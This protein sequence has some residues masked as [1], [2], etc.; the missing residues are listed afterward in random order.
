MKSTRD[1][2]THL[3]HLR[4]VAWAI[5][6][7]SLTAGFIVTSCRPKESPGESSERP[8]SS[9][10]EVM[11]T[12]EPLPPDLSGCTRIDLR[13]VPPVTSWLGLNDDNRHL[14]SVT[15]LKYLEAAKVV[16]LE[17]RDRIEALAFDVSQGKYDERTHGIPH[18]ADT[19]E[20]TGY[21]DGKPLPPFLARYNDYIQTQL[22]RGDVFRYPHGLPSIFARPLPG[23]GPLKMRMDCSENLL[24]LYDVISLYVQKEKVYPPAT[25]WCDAITSIRP[26]AGATEQD[27]RTRFICPDAG[28]GICHYGMNPDCTPDSA[29][30]TVLLFETRA[31]WNQHGGSESFV[32]NNHEPIGGCVLLN[33][34]GLGIREEPA[35]LPKKPTVLFIRTPEEAKGLRW[36]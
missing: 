16:T 32:L 15:E 13:F 30:E 12:G 10:G 6:G 8:T 18:P 28:K 23:V 9:S 31:G 2:G 11:G 21:R 25:E 1:H 5:T 36:K 29:P 26:W 14:L 24:L 19:V 27:I 7:V 20:V 35:V 34:G 33:D 22:Q 4:T 17:D 3:R